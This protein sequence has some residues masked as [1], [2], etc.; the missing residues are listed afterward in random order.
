MR[1]SLSET[2]SLG[3]AFPPASCSCPLPPRVPL[4]PLLPFARRSARIRSLTKSG[5]ESVQISDPR[6][7]LLG[8][9]SPSTTGPDAHSGGRFSPGTGIVA[10]ERGGSETHGHGHHRL[11]LVLRR[12]RSLIGSGRRGVLPALSERSSQQ[13]EPRTRRA[14]VGRG[15]RR[16]SCAG[17]RRT[18]WGAAELHHPGRAARPL[19]SEEVAP[20]ARRGPISQR[21]GASGRLHCALGATARSPRAEPT[22]GS[23]R[24]CARAR[25]GLSARRRRP[26]G[27]GV[28]AQQAAH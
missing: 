15:P 3:A 21:A 22:R 26:R 28:C 5:S 23:P 1:L 12:S 7:Q 18:Q 4:C 11:P 13:S 9:G 19:D 16:G 2:A 8:L 14:R 10:C 17:I 27:V 25:L 20:T 6:P 24:E